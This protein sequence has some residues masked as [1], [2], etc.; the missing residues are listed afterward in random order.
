MHI[1]ERIALLRK[2]QGMTQEQLADVLGTTRQAVSK[3]EAG[4]STPDIDYAVLMG[5]YFGVSMD[6]LIL[7][8]DTP[9]SNNAPQRPQAIS[10]NKRR[11]LNSNLFIILLT[12]GIC[13]IMLLPIFAM[14]RQVH[15]YNAHQ[16][17]Y[18]YLKEWPLLGLVILGIVLIVVGI[19]GWIWTY[20]R[21]KK[22]P[23]LFSFLFVDVEEQNNEAK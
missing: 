22:L 1:G 18:L 4:K 2:R 23:S 19:C 8:K 15:T 9:G 5:E 20:R 17:P 21:Q 3:W 6:Y 11:H 13:I 10:A 12:F 7:G 14:Y 16:D